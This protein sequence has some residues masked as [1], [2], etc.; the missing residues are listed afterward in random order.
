MKFNWIYIR[1]SCPLLLKGGFVFFSLIIWSFHYSLLASDSTR[2]QALYDSS[3]VY[4]YS[5]GS[6]A[7]NFAKEGYQLSKQSENY[8]GQLNLLQMMG[9]AYFTLGETE[10][11]IASFEE[12]LSLSE[13]RD[14]WEESA[15]NYVSLASIYTEQGI[16]SKALEH[17]DQAVRLFVATGDSS[18]LCDALL[19]YGNV[20]NDSGDH[21]EA[22]AQ[23][24]RSIEVCEAV[25]R[26]M[27][28]AYNYASIAILHDKQGEYE[29]AESYFLKAGEVFEEI[30]D[31]Y[32]IA[33]HHNNMGIFYKNIGAY[34][35]AIDAFERATAVFDSVGNERGLMACYS[36]LGIL[37]N[38]ISDFSKA[39]DFATLAL[40]ISRRFEDMEGN[41]DNLTSLAQA[42]LG[43]GNPEIALT[44]ALESRELAYF[45]ESLERQRDVNLVLS[46]IYHAFGRNELAFARYQD[47]IVA[48]DSLFDLDKNRQ[49]ND[50]RTKYETEKKDSEIA[51]LAKNAEID[52]VKKNRL[53]IGL[54]LTMIIGTLL[55]YAQW[56]RRKSEKKIFA[57]EQEISEQKAR[58]A[59][60]QNQQLQQELEFKQKE[61][62][63]KVLQLARKNEF[64]E[65]LDQRIQ[66]IS[67]QDQSG[68]TARLSRMIRSDISRENEWD[69]FLASFKEVHT[70]FLK[71]VQTSH[72]NLSKS[73]L[74]LICLMKMNLS[75]KEIANA[76]NI[77][78]DGVKKARYRLRKKMAVESEKNLQEHILNL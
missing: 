2:I 37:Y 34:Q 16:K 58:T 56:Q 70:D 23:Y 66:S 46:D 18:G 41:G 75:G 60:I 21:E 44:Y 65:E 59:Q 71:G 25:G 17:S 67:E 32:S 7:L 35:K 4:A 72:Q 48:K 55:I 51:L 49:M 12:A 15:N 69:D 10:Q 73:E 24:L 8:W 57:Q 38:K 42:E 31:T 13:S 68:Q 19:R 28:V 39:R 50:L 14:D 9:E 78:A 6:K 33:G 53:W 74:R 76:L 40:T 22:M 3:R 20:F 64:L 1:N 29:T 43:L 47:H 54:A 62:T 52:E 26:K 11:S 27:F 5:D 63:A 36:N 30:G 45:V 61:L 77:T